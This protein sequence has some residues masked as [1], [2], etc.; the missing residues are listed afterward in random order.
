ME[1]LEFRLRKKDSQAD[2]CSIRGLRA[3]HASSG[4]QSFRKAKLET[5]RDC[6]FRRSYLFAYLFGFCGLEERADLS[7]FSPVLLSQ[8]VS[9]D[10]EI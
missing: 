9:S 4:L 3:K 6:E 8:L 7:P 2:R 1:V 10:D 5:I